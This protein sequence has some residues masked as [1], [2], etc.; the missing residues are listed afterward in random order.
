MRHRHVERLRYMARTRGTEPHGEVPHHGLNGQRVGRLPCDVLSG[1]AGRGQRSGAARCRDELKVESPAEFDQFRTE[2][3]CHVEWYWQ[4]D[5][6][7]VQVQTY[8]RGREGC[9]DI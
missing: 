6:R 3:G 8:L 9:Y 2:G 4:H 1:V 5:V 7:L